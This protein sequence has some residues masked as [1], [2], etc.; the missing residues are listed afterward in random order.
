M[1]DYRRPI[2]TG[3]ELP[4][5][6]TSTP[7]V[8]LSCELCRQRKV[9]C[10]KLNPCTN[11]QRFGATCVPVERARLPRGRSGRVTGK[12]ASGHDTGL[13][14][15]VDRLE[16]LLRELTEHDDGTIAVQVDS[17]SSGRSDP[18]P[19]NK[20][21]DNYESGTENSLWANILK[22]I[23]DI[24]STQS[25]GSLNEGRTSNS[26]AM[27][28]RELL[29]TPMGLGSS[30][31]TT[32]PNLTIQAEKNLAQVFLKKVDPAF[33]ILHAP[34]LKAFL[35]D[36]KPYLD[37]GP[38]HTAPAALASAVYFAA[39]CSIT[40][41]ESKNL[42]GCNKGWLVARYQQESEAALAKADFMT[43]NDLAILQAF[44][45]FLLASRSQDSSRRVWT[46]LSMA[47]RIAQALLL[48]L[49]E[50]PF[51][52]RPF[53]H[54]LRRRLWT[55]IGLLDIQ[56]SLERASEP[57]MQAKWVELNPPSN[58]N[59]CDISFG[60]DGP[61]PEA[62]GFTDMTFA[63][64]TLKAQSTVRLLNFS[65]FIDKTVS[66][67]N[68]RQQLVIEFQETASKLLQ[69]SQPDQIPFHW[70]VRQVAEIISASL[71]LIV[72]R[73]LQRNANF[74]PPRVRG[75]RLLQIAV[76]ILKKS[77][78]VR[79]DPRGQPWR[80]C[81]FMFVPWHSLA[82]AIAELCVCE[83]HSLMESFWGPVREAYENMGDLIADSRRGMIWKPMEKIMAQAEAKRNELLAASDAI[84]Y[85]THFPG[86]A[87]PLQVPV[88]SQTSMQPSAALAGDII[89]GTGAYTEA[90][91]LVTLPET[92]ELG[93]WPSVWDAV[94]FGCPVATDEMSWLNYENFIE[95]VY[96]TMDYTLLAH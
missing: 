47:L 92:V 9:K 69:N 45:L 37:Y 44:V 89:P 95:D 35:L 42:L 29:A 7:R 94:D 79:N 34:S 51:P 70:Y 58:V 4:Q 73:P 83:D 25:Y 65:D 87:A 88:C 75:D 23:H 71:Q 19:A 28:F 68:K 66:C 32:E 40:E 84:P 61:V 11:C 63:M 21:A 57:M 24:R 50:L 39:A 27:K 96:G 74:V 22:E 67:V 36:G 64:V 15:R 91:P 12:N 49:P 30:M 72:L 93:P 14:E 16:E 52:V 53:E 43:S 77:K 85:S 56:C 55:Y 41:D 2:S 5:P 59:D 86:T 33:K 62:G 60:M 8:R 76:D 54:E 90:A 1:A 26:D 31:A 10:D 48:H 13:K 6:I 46:M 18:A 82:V 78:A 38:G 17:N 80:W 3:K 20:Q 81:E